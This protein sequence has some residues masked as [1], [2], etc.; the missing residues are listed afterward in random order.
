MVKRRAYVPG[1]QADRQETGLLAATDRVNEMQSRRRM[2]H[3]CCMS[4]YR[5]YGPYK[6][7]ECGWIPFAVQCKKCS[8]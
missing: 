4:D 6:Q 8:H 2:N 7:N 1:R 5:E 3:S